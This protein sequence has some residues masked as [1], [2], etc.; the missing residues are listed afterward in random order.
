MICMAPLSGITVALLTAMIKGFD[1][2]SPECSCYL[3]VPCSTHNLFWQVLC[4]AFVTLQSVSMRGVNQLL[5]RPRLVRA[6]FT[7]VEPFFSTQAGILRTGNVTSTFVRL[8]GIQSSNISSQLPLA[9]AIE[10]G[11]TFITESLDYKLIYI[12]SKAFFFGQI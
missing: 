12:C 4:S 8:R 5:S 7:S 9:A 11:K 1:P 2:A 10:T 6:G 3:R